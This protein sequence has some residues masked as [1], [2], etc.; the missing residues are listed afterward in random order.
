MLPSYD[1]RVYWESPSLSNMETSH[2][3]AV[4]QT[5]ASRLPVIHTLLCGEGCFLL[6]LVL[7]ASL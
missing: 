7:C 1:R 2:A 5:D 6:T 4:S 3:S